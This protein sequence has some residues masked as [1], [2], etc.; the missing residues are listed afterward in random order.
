MSDLAHIPVPGLAPVTDE[1]GAIPD[2]VSLLVA[3]G[4][5]FYEWDLESDALTW[6]G[7]LSGAVHIESHDTLASGEVM[8]YFDPSKDWIQIS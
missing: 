2:L 7:D 3:S 1:S 6:T 5:L 8:A 4:D